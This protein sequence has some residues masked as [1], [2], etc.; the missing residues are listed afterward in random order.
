M[1]ES[2]KG[3]DSYI[4]REFQIPDTPLN[5]YSPLT[6]AFI[7]DSIYDLVIR[8][9]VVGKGNTR[10]AKL[11]QETARLVKAT[12]QAKAMDRIEPSL[13]E[14]EQEIFRRG[15]NANSGTTA[16]NAPIADYRRATGFEALIGYLYL[17]DETER[18]MELIKKAIGDHEE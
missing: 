7:G 11:H 1:E 14:K 16:K 2:I 15:R 18:M 6:L 5:T 8:T 9:I 17:A 10:P 13:T 4:R 3:F 12:A